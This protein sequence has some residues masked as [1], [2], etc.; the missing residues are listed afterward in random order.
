[1]PPKVLS[2]PRDG[3]IGDGVKPVE[4]D[5]EFALQ[6]FLVIGLEFEL[7]RRKFRPERIVNQV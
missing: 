6:N 5:P 1:L 3:L 4:N 7:R 2:E